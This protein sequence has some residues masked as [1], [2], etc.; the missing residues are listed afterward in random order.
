M[1]FLHHA[2]VQMGNNRRRAPGTG[3]RGQPPR[4]A[5][6][7]PPESLQAA[8]A[9][10]V[11]GLAGPG[12]DGAR[13]GRHQEKLFRRPIRQGLDIPEDG[14][15]HPLPVSGQRGRRAGEIHMHRLHRVQLRRMPAQ[16]LEQLVQAEGGAGRTAP[17]AP[18]FH[19]LPQAPAF[20]S[21]LPP[22][23]RRKKSASSWAHSA[24]RM[25]PCHDTR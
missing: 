5:L 10:D 19:C 4:A 2:V 17:P 20:Q 6:L 16:L 18:A 14:R 9:Q 13:P 15:Q 25:P 21:S 12:G 24:A 11:S 1:H 8:A 7:Q 23:R 22:R 3:R